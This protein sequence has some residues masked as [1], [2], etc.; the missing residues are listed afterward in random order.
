[1]SIRVIVFRRSGR[2][3]Y[4]AQWKDPITGKKKTRST[5][6]TTLREAE[7]FAAKLEH[8]LV[9][10]PDIDPVKIKWSEFRDRYET[11]YA[12]TLAKKSQDKITTAF[13]SFEERVSPAWLASITASVVSQYAGRLRAE[14]LAPA[15]IKGY[16]SH[17][18]AAFNWAS[19]VGLMVESPHFEM[20]KRA[21]KSK[22]RAITEE[23][24]DRMLVK[25]PSVVGCE[26]SPRWEHFLRGL[27]WS[28]LRLGEAIALSWD[29]DEEIMVDLSGPRP[30]FR[31]R[32]EAEKGRKDRHLPMAPEFAELLQRIPKKERRG[33][34]FK[35]LETHSMKPKGRIKVYAASKV[36]C[37]IGSKARAIV[38]KKRSGESKH[39]SAHD[40]RRAFGFR[41]AMRVLPPVLMEL[42]R[43]ESITTTMQYYVGRN[44]EAAADA[45]WRSFGESA[46]DSTNTFADTTEN[47]GEA[48]PD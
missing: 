7:R 39:A 22:G 40:L 28:G 9:N 23:E 15:T 47:Q 42:M 44:A 13:N 5:K 31:V 4:E 24:F 30:M 38:G 17:L 16:L 45:V 11:E 2:K 46:H 35:Y 29:N 6:K 32:A 25:C 20:P 34:V 41:W 19:R 43:H 14:G 10:G 33:Y 27:Y 8:E 37:E 26:F 12:A 36:I 48:I 1:M 18:R 21:D 3:F